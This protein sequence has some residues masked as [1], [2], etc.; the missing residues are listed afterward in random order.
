M[1]AL[2]GARE[3]RDLMRGGESFSVEFKSDRGPLSDDELVEAAMEGPVAIIEVPAAPAWTATSKG[4]LLIRDYDATG[5]PV[6]RPFYPDEFTTWYAIQ[7]E[8]RRQRPFSVWGEIYAHST[9]RQ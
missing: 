9:T 1:G 3:L 5:R 8:N 6:C 4:K 7:E 2:Q